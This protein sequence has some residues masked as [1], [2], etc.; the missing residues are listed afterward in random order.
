M[1]SN[2]P[3]SAAIAYEVMMQNADVAAQM[4]ELSMAM[5]D[6]CEMFQPDTRA[7]RFNGYTQNM[8]R[9]CRPFN[10]TCEACGKDEAIE[11]GDGC[12]KCEIIGDLNWL[13]LERLARAM[14]HVASHL[15]WDKIAGTA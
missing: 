5:C 14:F 6:D 7:V 2:I 1:P 9:D 10:R 8:C 3:D 4:E 11:F 13:E 15:M 12:L